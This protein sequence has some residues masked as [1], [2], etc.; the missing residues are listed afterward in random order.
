MADSGHRFFS[1]VQQPKHPPYIG[2]G[3]QIHHR[4]VATREE[5]RVEAQDLLVRHLAEVPRVLQRLDGSESFGHM[6]R[7]SDAFVLHLQSKGSQALWA[8]L[9][10]DL[11]VV[12]QDLDEVA[13]L[14]PGSPCRPGDETPGA[15]M[16]HSA[17]Y[18]GLGH[19]PGRDKV[20]FS[21][22]VERHPD[23][24][25]IRCEAAYD[26]REEILVFVRI[27]KPWLKPN[28]ISMRRLS[29]WGGGHHFHVS[30]HEL[31]VG[32]EHFIRPVPGLMSLLGCKVNAAG[33]GN[34]H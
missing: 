23:I 11:G 22:V 14:S 10:R 24:V 16:I 5:D 29:I 17:Y 21:K 32:L 18:Q 31:V 25:Q 20:K 28:R 15:V 4:S 7:T 1:Q 34:N 9:A 19:P 30:R 3:S 13:V 8:Q 12:S 6:R 27:M 2:I 26:L 33:T